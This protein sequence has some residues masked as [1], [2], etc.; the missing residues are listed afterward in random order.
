MYGQ[1][2]F[3]ACEPLNMIVQT[4]YPDGCYTFMQCNVFKH[5]N[6][7]CSIIGNVAPSP[8]TSFGPGTPNS[9]WPSI[10]NTAEINAG[11][12]AWWRPSE[13]EQLVRSASNEQ[14]LE[15][16]CIVQITRRAIIHILA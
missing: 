4:F 14:N 10:N 6:H 2:S 5:K 15:N 11:V 9:F 7:E 16:L 3:K 8:N 13:H 1:F 12:T